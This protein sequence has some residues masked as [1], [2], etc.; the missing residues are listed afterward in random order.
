MEIEIEIDKKEVDVEIDKTYVF[1]T[2]Q[3]KTVIPSSQA[4]TISADPSYDG[5]SQVTVNAI[6]EEYIIPTGEIELTQNGTYDVKQYASAN[7]NLPQDEPINYNNT[8][9][10]SYAGTASYAITDIKLNL[11]NTKLKYL[12]QNFTS[13]INCELWFTGK[14]TTFQNMFYGTGSLD[15][16]VF[17]NLDASELT[18]VN[19]MFSRCFI[20]NGFLFDT[21]HVTDFVNFYIVS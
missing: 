18:S 3:E 11:Q 6:P 7:V 8:N 14:P 10:S 4:Q 12:F 17:H 9:E 1:P 13:L 2:L 15:N 20:K 19:S 16:I 5:L 21:S